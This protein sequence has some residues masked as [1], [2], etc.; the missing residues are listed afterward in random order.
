MTNIFNDTNRRL[1]I[2]TGHFLS[3]FKQYIVDSLYKSGETIAVIN[4][5]PVSIINNFIKIYD[6]S[7]K[8]SLKHDLLS[9]MESGF[10]EQTST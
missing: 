10:K 8:I 4:Y 2:E 5:R 7:S 9:N 1:T 3:E 6:K